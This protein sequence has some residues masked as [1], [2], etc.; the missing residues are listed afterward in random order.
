MP[1]IEGLLG[2]T[3]P[4]S[5]GTPRLSASHSQHVGVTIEPHGRLET[6]AFEGAG[7]L[8]LSLCY[9]LHHSTGE[10]DVNCVRDGIPVPECSNAIADPVAFVS[11]RVTGVF[12][13]FKRFIGVPD[14][15]Q[16][17]GELV[18]GHQLL[19]RFF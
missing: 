17:V 9:G 14:A 18:E 19:L 15:P 1:E 6:I 11:G 8:A 13:V 16:H 5:L 3:I 2:V 4:L 10:N 12:A 7:T